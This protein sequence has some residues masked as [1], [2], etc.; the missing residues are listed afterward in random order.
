MSFSFTSPAF[1]QFVAQLS[2]SQRNELENLIATLQ[3]VGDVYRL[4]DDDRL[5]LLQ[6]AQLFAGD[7]AQSAATT[8]TTERIEAST[9]SA[10]ATQ[11]STQFLRTP[12]VAFVRETLN[13]E[14]CT[15]GGSLADA[16][17]YA[18]HNKWMPDQWKNEDTCQQL[19]TKYKMEIES[20]NAWRAQIESVH[21]L[22]E[23]K[24]LAVGLA[25]FNTIFRL[26]QLLDNGVDLD[27]S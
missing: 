26:Q 8:D 22:N 19:F 1:A 3:R 6:Y 24:S 25:W 9:T 16:I 23:S 27:R 10:P 12:F 15:H 20:H 7:T 2:D 5:R 4:P 21:K 14:L 17:R 18:F 11:T 13:A